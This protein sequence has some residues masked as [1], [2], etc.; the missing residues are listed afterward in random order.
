MFLAVTD[1]LQKAQDQ[2]LSVTKCLN[3][4]KAYLTSWSIESRAQ[5]YSCIGSSVEATYIVVT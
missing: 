3:D 2:L 1:R 5:L 4:A